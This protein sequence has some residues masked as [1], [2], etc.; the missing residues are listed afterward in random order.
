[1][2]GDQIDVGDISASQGVAI[3]RGNVVRI[4]GDNAARIDASQLRAALDD[5]YDALGAAELSREQR[6]TAQTATGNARHAAADEGVDAGSVA[7]N[8]EQVGETLRHAGVAIDEGTALAE[9]VGR[10]AALLGPLVGGARVVAG[11]FGLPL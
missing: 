1:M 11:W 3:G 10:L 2:D 6:I 7:S 9:S 4:S 8:L 5:L